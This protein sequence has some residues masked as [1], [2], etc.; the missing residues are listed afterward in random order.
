M[1]LN[2]KVRRPYLLKGHNKAMTYRNLRNEFNTL[3]LLFHA[4]LLSGNTIV[5]FSLKH[6]RQKEKSTIFAKPTNNYY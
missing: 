2:K 6:Y 3:S 1:F 5:K 4:I